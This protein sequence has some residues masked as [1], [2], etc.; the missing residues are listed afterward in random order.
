MV[1]LSA[2]IVVAIRLLSIS[3]VVVLAQEQQVEYGVDVSFPMHHATVSDNYAWLEHNLDPSIPT[4]A[5]YKDK[6]V[7]PLGDRQSFYNDFLDGC[8]DHY[9]KKGGQRCI[10]TEAD[11]IEMSLRQP[12]SM[13]VGKKDENAGFAWLDS[14]AST[15]ED[16]STC[17]GT[18]GGHAVKFWCTKCERCGTFDVEL[19]V[20]FLTHAR[21]VY[22]I[23]HFRTTQPWVSRKFVPQM[24]CG[25]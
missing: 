20:I 3:S 5:E 11:R 25:L 19:F 15:I 22:M 1:S 8:V 12:Q 18:I 21:I 4:P 13:Q 16:S 7:Q 17:R 6:P 23:C 24:S 10:Q 14:S 2:K 9:G